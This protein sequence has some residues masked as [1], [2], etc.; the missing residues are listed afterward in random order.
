MDPFGLG[1][2]PPDHSLHD[3]S[4]LHHEPFAAGGPVYDSDVSRLA[5]VTG[6]TATFSRVPLKSLHAAGVRAVAVQTALDLSDLDVH[7]GAALGANDL[8]VPTAESPATFSAAIPAA[9]RVP[10]GEFRG[11]T[12]VVAAYRADLDDRGNPTAYQR[13]WRPILHVETLPYVGKVYD[14]EVAGSGSF[15]TSDLV[16]HNCPVHHRTHL[17]VHSLPGPLWEPLR[18]WRHDT[19]PPAEVVTE[20]EAHSHD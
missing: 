15:V 12:V 17:G 6:G 10:L 9:R 19:A 8:G 2:K 14:I 13:C 20:R 11:D 3:E 1:E 18:V 5:D 4:M 7:L 16:V